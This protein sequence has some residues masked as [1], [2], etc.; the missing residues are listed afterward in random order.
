[1]GAAGPVDA[2]QHVLP[3]TSSARQLGQCGPQ[4][5]DVVGD[6]VRA[7]VARPQS[8][9]QRLSGPLGPVVDER[10]QRMKAEAALERRRRGLLSEC[11]VTRVA[12]TSIISGRE[13]FVSWS[14]A[15][16]PASDQ[17]L[18]RAVAR[19]EAIAANAAGASA[20]RRSISRDTIGSDATGPNTSGAAR[21]CARSARQS[22]PTARL[23]ARSS[24]ILPGSWRAIGRRH[25]SSA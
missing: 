21:S 10:P 25:G 6:G 9:R 22:P 1:M 19:A 23:T 2:D 15:W 17:A 20:A 16:S 13:A 18:A 3:G 7:G 5:G 8:E 12:S 14:G 24:R 4:H 11:A